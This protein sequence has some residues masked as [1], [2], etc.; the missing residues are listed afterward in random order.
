MSACGPHA[1]CSRRPLRAAKPSEA[2]SYATGD[3]RGAEELCGGPLPH[4][5]SWVPV[6]PGASASLL[7][8][9]AEGQ[10]SLSPLHRSLCSP[11]RMDSKMA[12][13]NVSLCGRLLH[14]PHASSGRKPGG[15]TRRQGPM[16]VREDPAG[17][18]PDLTQ[19][20]EHHPQRSTA[21]PGPFQGPSES[22][23]ARRFPQYL[24]HCP[25]LSRPPPP[26][27]SQN[28]RGLSA[29]GPAS[30]EGARGPGLRSGDS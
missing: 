16:R 6:A 17:R 11:S 20:A 8:C 24:R 28:G 21:R 14:R 23:R 26:N 30:R 7:P 15:V 9:S 29:G 4:G 10:G 25:Q 12:H 18:R 19:K 1:A 22:P 3:N 5:R 2:P 27:V 13:L